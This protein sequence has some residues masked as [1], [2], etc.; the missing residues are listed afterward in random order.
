MMKFKTGFLTLIMLI[1]VI[2]ANAESEPK[3]TEFE[4]N[5]LKVILRESVKGTVSA[6]LF[7]KGGTS[8]YDKSKEGVESLALSLVMQSGPTD[9]TNDAFNL[10]A[11]AVGAQMSANSGYDY[12][13]MSLNCVKIYWDESWK[14]FSDAI[15]NPAWRPEE[16]TILQN[17]M[18]T[19]S[20]QSKTN[21]DAHLRN[22]AFEN[23]WSGTNYANIPD[24][25]PGSLE[26]LTIEDLKKHYNKVVV[27]DN[28]FLVVVGDISVEDLKKKITES[29]ANLPKGKPAAVAQN[30]SQVKEGLSVENRELETNYILGIFDAPKRGTEEAVENDLAMSI[31]GDRFFEELRTKRSLSYA[32]AASRTG[33]MAHPMNIVYISTTDPE[34]SLQV[35]VDEIN[36]VKKDGFTEKELAGKKQSYL[37]RYYMGQETN[38]SIAMGLGVNEMNGGWEK[39]DTYTKEILETDVSDLNAIMQKYG[40]QIYWT[41]LGKEALVKPEF[42]LQPV[43]MEKLKK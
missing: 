7:V 22:I 37:T 29:L 19:A 35:M 4:V 32:P 14:L 25:T 26:A 15:V 43:K 21:A 16:F 36:K 18:V 38:S 23:A 31:L 5:G 33:N 12:G 2:S 9:M 28:V 24:G 11:E 30:D 13:T 34:Q 3:T 10:A 27:K 17:Q 41:Y 40:D 39:M 42:F 20:K 1:G 6:R 8:G